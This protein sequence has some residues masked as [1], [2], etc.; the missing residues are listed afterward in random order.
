MHPR[1][2]GIAGV[3]LVA[4]PVLGVLA[5]AFYGRRFADFDRTEIVPAVLI[6]V[7]AP[8]LSAAITAM[9]L[10]ALRSRL[11]RL[12]LSICLPVL[13]ML[14]ARTF[15]STYSAYHFD[16]ESRAYLGYLSVVVG[17][18]SLAIVLLTSLAATLAAALAVAV[19]GINSGARLAAFLAATAASL[20]FTGLFALAA[21]GHLNTHDAMSMVL[22]VAILLFGAAALLNAVCK[23]HVSAQRASSDA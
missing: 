3:A 22:L 1:R 12:L 23:V 20:A 14:A 16:R 18:T 10:L 4:L 2:I 15:L 13:A 6:F 17:Q 5:Q 7:L 11:L 9:P 19:R 21:V 8:A